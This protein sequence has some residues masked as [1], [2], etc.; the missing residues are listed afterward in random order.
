MSL[1]PTL[2]CVTFICFQSFSLTLYCCLLLAEIERIIPRPK[3]FQGRRTSQNLSTGGSPTGEGSSSSLSRSSHQQ[4]F[5]PAAG[6]HRRNSS[7]TTVS[8]D[9]T[10]SRHQIASQDLS[11]NGKGLSPIADS[12]GFK[13]ERQT[14]GAASTSLSPHPSSANHTHTFTSTVSV[15]NDSAPLP[16]PPSVRTHGRFLA[17]HRQ[18]SHFVVT[19]FATA[20]STSGRLVNKT[21]LWWSEYMSPSGPLLP[22]GA[23]S[24][25]FGGSSSVS[26]IPI[27]RGLGRSRWLKALLFIWTAFSCLFTLLHGSVRLSG[28]RISGGRIGGAALENVAKEE[29][30]VD[31]D[32]LLNI[33]NAYGYVTTHSDLNNLTTSIKLNKAFSKSIPSQ[34]EHVLPYW[35]TAEDDVQ[36]IESEELL[37]LDEKLAQDLGRDG[38]G[39]STDKKQSAGKRPLAEITLTTVVMASEF[40][41]LVGFA[42][43]W[44]GPVSAT[45]HVESPTDPVPQS[46]RDF[47]S[48]IKRK[49]QAHPSL[50]KHVTIHLVVT[51]PLKN[52][53]LALNKNMD[54]NI[55]RLFSQTEFYM[56]IEPNIIPVTNIRQTMAENQ[57]LFIPRLQ[58]GYMFV[59]PT[60]SPLKV[61]QQA[62]SQE[63]N[64]WVRNGVNV[65]QQQRE[66]TNTLNVPLP[67]TKSALVTA[68]SEGHFALDDTHWDLGAGPTCYEHWSQVSKVYPAEE[69]EFHYQPVVIASKKVTSWCPERFMDNKAS[70]LFGSYLMG[71]EFWVL[72]DDFVIKLGVRETSSATFEHVVPED[73]DTHHEVHPTLDQGS[74]LPPQPY[75]KGS[76]VHVSD[77]EATI[78]NRLYNKFHWEQCVFYARQLFSAGLWDTPRSRHAKSQC[79]R[80]LNSWG[81]GLIGGKE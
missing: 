62:D 67:R 71:G 52:P 1:K 20:T 76:G 14:D 54:R 68:V 15:P 42:E 2:N 39:R 43:R 72:P 38:Q 7:L 66:T 34:L 4:H 26:R 30:P 40:E 25:A 44:Q 60:F 32:R 13:S 8:I 47:L 21:K 77:F 51:A 53:N 24:K 79:S 55:A 78:A 36:Y 80:V 18:K 22:R 70:C 6:H 10:L 27:L 16:A 65:V 46:T 41:S 50:K 49:H 37:H 9:T 74:I 48:A 29:S 75:E 45:L 19:P 28:G 63:E 69:Y 61:I 58:M 5:Q 64:P 31:V 56:Y 17:P 59:V 35:L 73:D 57:D 12:P 11:L 23:M 81:R 33:G 3:S